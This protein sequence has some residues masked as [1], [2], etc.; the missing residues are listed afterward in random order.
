MSKGL[1]LTDSSTHHL[2]IIFCSWFI[3]LLSLKKKKKQYVSHIPFLKHYYLN[4]Y[5]LMTALNY[6]NKVKIVES[7]DYFPMV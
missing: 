6:D 1:M 2:V 5:S 7:V 4:I 3:K